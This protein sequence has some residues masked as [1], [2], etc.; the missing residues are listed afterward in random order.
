MSD[1]ERLGSTAPAYSEAC[2]SPLLTVLPEARAREVANSSQKRHCFLMT[3]RQSDSDSMVRC[4]HQ[5]LEDR[6]HTGL[7]GK[8]GCGPFHF[9]TIVGDTTKQWGT[10]CYRASHHGKHPTT[11]P[12]DLPV[13][14]S[15][16]RYLAGRNGTQRHRRCDTIFPYNALTRGTTHATAHTFHPR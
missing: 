4:Q 1:T 10:V 9:R 16:P 8:D 7:H 5:L 6:A 15:L 14:P 13:I 3:T 11:V 12:N 2:L